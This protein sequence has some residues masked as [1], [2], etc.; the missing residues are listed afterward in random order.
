M[1]AAGDPS[2]ET[3][4]GK[5]RK[6]PV[7]AILSV[8]LALVGAA[9]GYFLVPKFVHSG[10]AS[11]TEVTAGET[12][13]APHSADKS[14]EDHKDKAKSSHEAVNEHGGAQG[15]GASAKCDT[16]CGAAFEVIG[17]IAYYKPE[18][19][20]VSIRPRARLRHLKIAVVVETSPDAEQIFRDNSLRIRDALTSYLRAVDPAALEDPDAFQEIR[21]AISLRISTVVRPAPVRAVLITDFILT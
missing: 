21:S 7:L 3:A 9:A 14:Q 2:E 1:S 11:E 12:D 17:D 18:P 20:V 13:S 15:D 16:D 5:K 8:G 6:I 19:L 10:A 4:S